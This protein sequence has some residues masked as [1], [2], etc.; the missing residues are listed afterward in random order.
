MLRRAILTG[1]LGLVLI[2]LGAGMA[3]AGWILINGQL[4]WRSLDW[5]LLYK[6]VS[7]APGDTE[8]IINIESNV[9]LIEGFCANNPEQGPNYNS[10]VYAVDATISTSVTVNDEDSTKDKGRVLVLEDQPTT[11]LLQIPDLCT[12]GHHLIAVNPLALT[13]TIT[14]IGPDEIVDS[15]YK[16]SCSTDAKGVPFSGGEVYQCTFEEVYR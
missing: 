13:A 12:P 15:I 6:A 11:D 10:A 16:A 4:R 7:G 9:T 8:E 5:S 3:N 14:A 1:C 2:V